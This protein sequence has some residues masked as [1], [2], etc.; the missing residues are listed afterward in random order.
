MM[1]RGI[2]A[3]FSEVAE[4]YEL[5]NHILT[6]GLDRSWRKQAARLAARAGGTLWLDVC[7]GTGEMA[8]SLRRY[9][10]ER[11]RIVV[12]DFNAA[13]LAR[14]SDKSAGRDFLLTIAEAGRL[15]F[16]DRTFGL[17]TIS[18]ATRNINAS[19]DALL[20]HLREFRRV[21]RPGGCFINLETSQPRHPVIKKLFHAYIKLAV[22][23]VGTFLTGSRAGY[24]YLSSTIPRFYEAADFS[25]LL[26]Q[27]GFARVD[28]NP[29]FFGAAAIHVAQ[30][31][32]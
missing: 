32:K 26:R 22:R 31:E 30:Y 4:R 15:P 11:A 1:N 5:V 7:S 12:V 29:L 6:F 24:A 16:A 2:Q 27:A 23:P 9:S 17:V 18:F 13:M 10:D 3:I 19:T 21:L 8:E 28:E 20:K 25:R 14:V